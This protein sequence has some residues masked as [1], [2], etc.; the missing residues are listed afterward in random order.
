MTVFVTG[1]SYA[2]AGFSTQTNILDLETGELL[3]DLEKFT[4]T[5]DGDEVTAIDRNYW[6]VTFKP[7]S[8][9][10]YATLQTGGKISLIEGDVS[11]RRGQVIDADVECPSLSPDG[12]K[13]AFKQR[14]DASSLE[15]VTWG[16]AVLD[17]ETGQRWTLPETRSVDDQPAWLDDDTVIYGL[18]SD[19]ASSAETD[20]WQIPADGS[21]APERWITR[22][23]SPSVVAS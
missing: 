18:P 8:D 10:F 11:D 14:K 9:G 4:V 12:T 21:G 15:A 1:H 6:G 20:V 7:D 22:A 3:P 16:I 5:K 23:W 13:I 19:G 2:Q 17:L